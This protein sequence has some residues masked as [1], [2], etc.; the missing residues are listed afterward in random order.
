MNRMEQIQYLNRS[1]LSEMPEYQ[2]QAAQF[3]QELTAQQI[4]RAH[5]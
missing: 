4:G 3:P 5:V 1:L 2:G